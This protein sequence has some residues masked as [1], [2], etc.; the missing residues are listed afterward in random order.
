MRQTG[1]TASGDCGSFSVTPYGV[2]FNV[3]T[4]RYALTGTLQTEDVPSFCDMA[5]SAVY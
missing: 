3:L 2:I 5:S 1:E 4:E